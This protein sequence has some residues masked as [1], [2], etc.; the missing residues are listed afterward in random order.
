[1]KKFL[2]A[3]RWDFIRQVRY[4]I[5]FI[6]LGVTLVY[7]G[8][9]ELIPFGEFKPWVLTFIL[10]TDPTI[11]GML[12][13][14]SLLLFE[15]SEGTLSAI[16]VTPLQRSHYLWSKALSLT[17][18][19]LLSSIAIVAGSYGW[20]FNW[21]YLILGVVLSSL[22]FSFIGLCV[23][24]YVRSFN[25][26]IIRLVIYFLPLS[27][28]LLNFLE[29][30]DTFWFYLIPTQATLLLLEG[31]FNGIAPWQAIYSIAYLTIATVVV[32]WGALR[33]FRKKY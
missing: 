31:S 21:M 29:V 2:W 19:A 11:L 6:V 32:H 8:V 14:G 12:F 9:L 20:Q 13:V 18:M 7:L 28:P 17:V 16:V 22:L 27:L 26:Y 23:V 25:A 10:Y 1:M 30:T 3:L 24:F 5:A 4:N 33:I 15:Q